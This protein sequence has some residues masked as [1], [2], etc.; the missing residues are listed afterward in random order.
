[1]TKLFSTY[2]NPKFWLLNVNVG[3]DSTGFIATVYELNLFF[4]PYCEPR[5]EWMG[6]IGRAWRDKRICG[7]GTLSLLILS[8]GGIYLQRTRQTMYRTASTQSPHQDFTASQRALQ[9][10]VTVDQGPYT[11]SST[12][13]P[14]YKTSCPGCG[15]LCLQG[16]DR[17]K[18]FSIYLLLSGWPDGGSVVTFPGPFKIM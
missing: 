17:H 6:L 3:W 2:S 18:T 12:L 13:I 7:G 11:H 16:S 14:G 4:S 1:M 10:Q 5:L 15:L 9:P 8:V